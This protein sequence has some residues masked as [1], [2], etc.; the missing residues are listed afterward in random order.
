MP[1]IT[2]QSERLDGNETAWFSR[3]N[4][5]INKN[6]YSTVYPENKGRL[7][8]PDETEARGAGKVYT[9]GMATQYG[10]AKE[11]AN[12]ADDLPRAGVAVSDQSRLIKTYGM[13]WGWDF[14]EIKEAVRTGRDLPRMEAD[15]AR[16]AIDNRVDKTLATGDG[17]LILGLLNQTSTTTI[18]LGNKSGGGKTWALATSLEIVEDFTIALQA[19]LGAI[20]TAGGIAFQRFQ[21][22]LPIAQDTLIA[23]RPMGNGIDKTIK[24]H[25]LESMKENISAIDGWDRCRGAGAT[26]SDRMAFYPKTQLV[27]GAVVAEDFTIRSP[28]ERNLATVVPAY[29]RCG[30]V[31]CRYP[32]AM[33]YGDGL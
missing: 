6:L 24:Q 27:L 11:V 25:I 23:T 16:L 5:T 13:S 2:Q 4:E 9:W 3:E 17:A 22:V 18:T 8:I 32:F 29:A 26:G 12:M 14:V 7:L 28:Q 19:L 31:V 1:P 30:G 21:V 10:E 15:A 33:G 20:K